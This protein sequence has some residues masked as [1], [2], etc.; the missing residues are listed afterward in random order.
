[1]S[2]R[3]VQ[4]N[5]TAEDFRG[6]AS[7]ETAE[8]EAAPAQSTSEEQ[9][10]SNQETSPSSDEEEEED[11][12]EQAPEGTVREVLS[13]VNGDKARAQR[14]LDKENEDDEP[15]SSLVDRLRKIAEG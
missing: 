3:H 2:E 13:W 12:D 6:G 1:M 15:R 10:T 14:A 4:T 5:F 7:T 11:D 9:Q 8:N